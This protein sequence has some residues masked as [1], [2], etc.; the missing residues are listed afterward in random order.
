MK[1]YVNYVKTIQGFSEDLQ[2]TEEDK[3]QTKR[4]TWA[5][6]Q[7][8]L[9]DGGGRGWGGLFGWRID[10]RYGHDRGF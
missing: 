2:K 1:K 5:K 8:E 3:L 7:Q 4:G 9:R 6:T 10:C